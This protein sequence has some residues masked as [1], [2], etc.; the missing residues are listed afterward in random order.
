MTVDN[1]YRFDNAE[2]VQREYRIGLKEKVPEG[3]RR[4]HILR[5]EWGQHEIRVEGQELVCLLSQGPV[6][7]GELDWMQEVVEGIRSELG[8]DFA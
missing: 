5:T 7:A 6:T 8:T 1:R 2:R 3:Y 4:R